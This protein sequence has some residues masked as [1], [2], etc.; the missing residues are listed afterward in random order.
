MVSQGQPRA[1]PRLHLWDTILVPWLP[2]L[3]RSPDFVRH[4]YGV[5]EE[6]LDVRKVDN[7]DHCAYTL[8]TWGR[9]FQASSFLEGSLRGSC[10]EEGL[11]GSCL[12]ASLSGS[13]LEASLGGSCLEASLGGSCLEASLGWRRYFEGPKW[14]CLE[15]SG[16]FGTIW[17]TM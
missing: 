17:G 11:A 8:K 10:L 7:W 1:L 6:K 15:S 5:L 9:D 4:D 16:C 3:Y 14:R 12:E 13:C 2:V